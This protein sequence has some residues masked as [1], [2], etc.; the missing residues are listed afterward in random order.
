MKIAFLLVFIIGHLV[1][2]SAFITSNELEKKLNEKNLVLLD[3]TDSKTYKDGHIPMAVNVNVADFRKKVDTYSLIQSSQKIQELA[4]NLG[5]NNN[6]EV[7][8]YGHGLPKE[9]LK[10]SYIALALMSNGLENVSL[11]DGAYSDWLF[12][13]SERTSKKVPSVKT[14]DFIAKNNPNILVDLKY[15]KNHISLVQMIES[16]P[17]R[18]YHG[19]D[20]SNGVRRLG[21]IPNAMSSF[22]KDKFNSDD[23]IL[24]REELNTIYLTNHKLDKNKEVIIYCTGGLEASMNWY[25]MTRHLGFSNAKVYDASMRQ[26]G[27]RDDTPMVVTK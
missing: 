24:T 9:L 3:V 5:I 21:H 2:S 10:S 12:E 13:Y 8:I 23:S 27:N 19:S 14:G 26:W 4:R 1:A 17:E 16:R 22:W 11:L 6:S 18:Y 7:V 15:V 25:I 20:K